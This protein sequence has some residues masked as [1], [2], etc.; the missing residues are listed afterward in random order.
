MNF[1]RILARQLLA[2]DILAFFGDLGAGKTC[3]IK[4]I[5]QGLGVPEKVY[6]T[7]PTFVIINRYKGRLPIYHFDFYR[8]SCLDEIIDLGYEEFFFGGGVCL[9]EW[10]DRAEDLLPDDYF[11]ILMHHVSPSE[12]KIEVIAYGSDYQKRLSGLHLIYEE[13]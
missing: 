3:L 13:I 1:G 5:C 4:G 12:R 10:A 2:G 11:K 9:I 6:I 8:L 7:S